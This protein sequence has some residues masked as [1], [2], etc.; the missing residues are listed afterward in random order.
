MSKQC[1]VQ[2]QNNIIKCPASDYQKLHQ[3][4]IMKISKYENKK[5]C[6]KKTFMN[7]K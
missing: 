3:L 5:Y 2:L 4:D 7:R 1:T 6:Y